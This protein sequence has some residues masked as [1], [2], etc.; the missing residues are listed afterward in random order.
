ML[1][2]MLTVL[3]LNVNMLNVIRWIVVILNVVSPMF[4]NFSV[5]LSTCSTEI[6][7]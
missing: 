2:V 4:D 7:E 6:N 3:V 1:I 5:Y